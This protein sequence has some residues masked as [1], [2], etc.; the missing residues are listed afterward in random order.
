MYGFDDRSL[1]CFYLHNFGQLLVRLLKLLM[2][3]TSFG[4]N[5]LYEIPLGGPPYLLIIDPESN[6]TL[7]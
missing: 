7:R 6:A 2:A 4:I 5:S 3:S 1:K